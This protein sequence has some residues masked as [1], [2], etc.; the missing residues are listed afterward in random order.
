MGNDR[1]KVSMLPNAIREEINLKLRN[2]WRYDQIS[3]WLFETRVGTDAEH[4]QL[5]PGD[6]CSLFW[7]RDCKN[8]SIARNACQQ[9]LSRWFKTGYQKWLN[10]LADREEAIRLLEHV[11]R[12][13]TTANEKGQ[14]DSNLGGNLLIRSMLFDAIQQIRNKHKDPADLARL[15]NAWARMSQT[16]TGVEALK[17]RK[18]E[19]ID[20]GLQ[21]LYDEAKGNPEAM[22]QFHKFHEIVKQSVKQTS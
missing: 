4:L 5:K 18:Q 12:L 13:S 9:S 11:E 3:H 8:E 21:A 20:A 14:P 1:T 2:G 6:S 15:A 10:D 16:A 22:K 17:L 19:G 7:M